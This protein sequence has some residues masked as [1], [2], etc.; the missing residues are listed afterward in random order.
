VERKKDK[1]DG[2]E[3]LGDKRKCKFCQRYKPD[4]AHHCRICKN[5]VLRMD[6]HFPWIANCVGFHN[7]KFFLN[8]LLYAI[9]LLVFMLG[10]MFPRLL[11]VFQPILDIHYFLKK[12]MVVIVAF[13]V[14]FF[15]FIT[16]FMFFGFHI[17]MVL[18][19]MTTIEYREKSHYKKTFLASHIKFNYSYYQNF[20]HIFGPPWM[21][22]LPM[23]P[24]KDHFVTLQYNFLKNVPDSKNGTVEN[25]RRE[26]LEYLKS[27]GSR[28]EYI[29]EAGSYYTPLPKDKNFQLW[30][31]SIPE[32][33]NIPDQKPPPQQIQDN[34]DDMSLEQL[35][36]KFQM[37]KDENE[38]INSKNQL[39]T[40]LGPA[41]L[42]SDGDEDGDTSE[43]EFGDGKERQIISI[44]DDFQP[45]T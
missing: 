28:E 27:K 6:H 41:N 18:N 40:P 38:N 12:D 23:S 17:W 26:V 19:A 10:A 39:T 24:P 43:E 35:A 36:V 7:Y 2:P 16:L 8:L 34:E 11:N 14:C 37:D 9:C 1:T 22:V 13:I 25:A 4:R 3:K 42:V 45:G 5:C 15:F 33:E 29:E 32:L 21:W 20:T 31:L 30:K 44:K